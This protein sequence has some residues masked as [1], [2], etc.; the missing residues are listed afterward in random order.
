MGGG[1]SLPAAGGSPSLAERKGAQQ[2]AMVCSMEPSWRALDTAPRTLCPVATRTLRLAPHPPAAPADPRSAAF[3]SHS[4]VM[5][6]L[7]KKRCHLRNKYHAQIRQ[8]RTECGIKGDGDCLP[9][10]EL[11]RGAGGGGPG[12]GRGAGRWGRQ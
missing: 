7:M 1:A 6:G 10:A 3:A 5:R 11:V 4:E 9:T 12:A 2:G 8:W